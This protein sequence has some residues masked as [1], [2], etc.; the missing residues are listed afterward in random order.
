VCLFLFSMRSYLTI[1]AAAAALTAVVT[2]FASWMLD[3]YG[4]AHPLAGKV[5][6]QP[7][8]RASKTA[9]LAKACRQFNSY[10]LGNSRSQILQGSQFADAGAAR[11]Y[12][13]SAPGE[14]IGQDLEQL[15][16]LFR[17]GC[18]VSALLVA[19]SV[20]VFD[21]FG[22]PG[23]DALNQIR[24]PL[25]TGDNLLL[26]YGRYYLGPQGAIAFFRSK[27]SPRLRP[28]FYY[29]DGH[30]DYLWEMQSDADYTLP[31]CRIS[32][33]SAQQ[34]IDLYGR[35][36]RYRKLAS[37]A[38][39]HHVK[40]VVWLTPLSK[41]RSIVLGDP[42]VSRYIRELNQIVGLSV[43]EADRDSPLLSDFHQW[44]DCS[45]FH[46]LVFDQL[47]AP[48]VAKLLNE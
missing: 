44:H 43:F 36:P 14:D 35:L 42:D 9:F 24:H 13:F 34:K 22:H 39:Q 33:L 48:G 5:L 2:S 1:L 8:D 30:L 10:V 41:A 20:D 25:I 23:R 32:R 40:V 4:I 37:L 45:H 19:E 6:M 46:R 28:M 15:E 47:V 21:V 12:N 29:P 38:A 17:R 7:N 16:F 26:F 27:H 31:V 18:P 3:P 11:Y